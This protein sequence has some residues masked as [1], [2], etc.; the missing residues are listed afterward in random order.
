MAEENRNFEQNFVFA[1]RE[2]ES[3]FKEENPE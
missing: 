2:L 3:I 1:F